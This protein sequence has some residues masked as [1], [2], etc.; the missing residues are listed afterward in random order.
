[1]EFW[2]T[3]RHVPILKDRHEKWW[4]TKQVSARSHH[5]AGCKQT[6]LPGWW[7]RS[8]K[9]VTPVSRQSPVIVLTAI[10]LAR[11]NRLHMEVVAHA[12]RDSIAIF[13]SLDALFRQGL[14]FRTTTASQIV[15]PAENCQI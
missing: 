15:K 7:L 6:N 1:M 14:D 4:I 9:P 11:L 2:P 5:R 10:S 12:I 8:E 13:T 3:R